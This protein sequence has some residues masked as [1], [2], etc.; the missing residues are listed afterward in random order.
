[1][2]IKIKRIYSE[3][4]ADDGLR[5]F[6]DRLWARGLTKE[7]AEIDLWAKDIAP[8]TELRKWYGHDA[9]KFAEFKKKYFAELDANEK[10]KD[11]LSAISACKGTVTLLF[12]AKNGEYS[13]AAVL[14]EWIRG[15]VEQITS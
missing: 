15:K 8:S 2:D 14:A 9:E 13:N 4:S 5:V 7:K 1:M 12:A 3:P 11:F 10:A 6:V